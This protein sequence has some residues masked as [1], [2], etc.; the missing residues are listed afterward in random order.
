MSN[1]VEIA[2]IL[3]EKNSSPASVQRK[4]FREGSC[5][6]ENGQ[7]LSKMH[8]IFFS[9]FVFMGAEVLRTKSF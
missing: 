1:L 8:M 3:S 9:Y 7:R 4:K 6:S 2:H 5:Y